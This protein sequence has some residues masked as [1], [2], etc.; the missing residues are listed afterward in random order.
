MLGTG[1]DFVMSFFFI[2]TG[3]RIGGRSPYALF[4]SVGGLKMK[5]DPFGDMRIIIR[6]MYR[7]LWARL[8]WLEGGVE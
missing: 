3:R 4:T 7:A 2:S 8:G 6:G 1:Y 5:G